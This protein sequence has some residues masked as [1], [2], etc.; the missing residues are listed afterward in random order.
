[1]PGITSIND[2]IDLK[3]LAKAA[4]PSKMLLKTDP[5]LGENAGTSC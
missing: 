4:K 1:M 2:L 3:Q 5:T